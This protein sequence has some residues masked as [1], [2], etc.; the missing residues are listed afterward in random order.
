MNFQSRPYKFLQKAIRSLPHHA[1]IGAGLS[2][3]RDGASS[4]R[5]ATHRPPPMITGAQPRPLLRLTC[6]STLAAGPCWT[7]PSGHWPPLRLART[8]AP[9]G[10]WRALAAPWRPATPRWLPMA[11]G[12]AGP[13]RRPMA[14]GAPGG[15]PWRAAVWRPE[16]EPHGG[17]PGDHPD[18]PGCGRGDHGRSPM[19]R[20]D[21]RR[22]PMAVVRGGDPPWRRAAA[23]TGGAPWRRNGDHGYSPLEA[24]RRQF[25]A[26]ITFF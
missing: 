7:T 2:R 26:T 13:E 24:R 16:P 12:S 8:S 1:T 21:R 19:A 14:G 17:A 11:G 10:G 18:H 5:R 15:S 4:A 20:G 25:K 22:N 23:T 9:H 6:F 3:P